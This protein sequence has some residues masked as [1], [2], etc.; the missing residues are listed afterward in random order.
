MGSDSQL[1]NSVGATMRMQYRNPVYPY[2]FADPFVLRTNKGYYAYGTATVGPGE[3]I[4]P[5][6][7]SENL[8]QWQRIGGALVPLKEPRI[9]AYWAP[10]VAEK[11]GRYY[12]FYSASDTPSDEGHRLRVAVAND[13]A[14]PF[15]DGGRELLP[16]AGFTIDASPF[17]DPKTGDFYL[18]FATDF[19][20]DEPFG[21]GLAVVALDTTLLSAKGQAVPILRAQGDWQI[22][23]RNRPYKGKTW[24]KWHTVEGP[25]CI[26]HE[27]K[28]YC[29][30]S[31]GAWHGENYGVGFAVA[32]HPLGPWQ[33]QFGDQGAS[34]L[35]G[36]PGR[37][38]GP[39]HNSCVRGPLNG[40]MYMVYHAWDA[41]KTARRM[42]MDPVLWTPA[43]PRVDGPSTEEREL[44]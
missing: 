17:R 16:A 9:Y 36:I 30:Y 32:D 19:E 3:N 13:P 22:F 7:H 24:T 21:T 42:C 20:S 25:H 33:D 23:E 40:T 37:V 38:I 14:G 39:G 5:I 43:G 2:D 11:D 8:V 15:E 31:G 10:E 4:F 35:K 26:Y 44:V 29:F 1:A 27:G 41:Q 34:V 28:Y 12:L 6:L 18:F